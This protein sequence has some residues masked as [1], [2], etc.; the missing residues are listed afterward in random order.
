MTWDEVEKAVVMAGELRALLDG[1]IPLGEGF[2]SVTRAF[3]SLANKQADVLEDTLLA[4]AEYRRRM[5]Q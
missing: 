1:P 5:Y 2:D 3:V 4:A